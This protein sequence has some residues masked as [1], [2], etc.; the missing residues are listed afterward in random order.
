LRYSFLCFFIQ[1]FLWKKKNPPERAEIKK[2]LVIR[3]DHIGDMMVSL[4]ALELLR[5]AF[6]CAEISILAQPDKAK[7]LACFPAIDKIILYQGLLKTVKQLRGER[8]DLAIDFL[9]DYRLKSA[10]LTYFSRA[11]FTAGFDI[12]GKGC[13]FGLKSNPAKEKKHISEYTLDLITAIAEYFSVGNISTGIS[14]PELIVSEEN[15]DYA[16]SLLREKGAQEGELLVAI[17]PGGYSSK[18]WPVE[19]FSRLADRI[20]REHKAKVILIGGSR[21]E[22]RIAHLLNLMQERALKITGLSLD[23][24]AGLISLMHLFIGNNAGPLHI[25]TALNIPT[26][27]V[28][29][30]T[31]PILWQPSG[32]RNVVLRKNLACSPCNKLRA[33]RDHNCMKS[34]TIEEMF[35]AVQIQIEQRQSLNYNS[36]VVR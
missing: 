5:Q 36:L 7:L 11:K 16:K 4:P 24:L 9:M 29:G 20:I 21:D 8:F 13:F 26:V 10:L 3:I 23:K 35:A 22:S 31:D 2:I 28:M 19:R 34:I 18:C 33:C 17:H 32:R 12:I 1:P 30:P 15:R 27:S 6:P 14:Y 25:A